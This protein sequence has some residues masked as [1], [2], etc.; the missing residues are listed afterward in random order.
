MKWNHRKDLKTKNFLEPSRLQCK[1]CTI[2]NEDIRKIPHRLEEYR[3][4]IRLILLGLPSEEAG[5]RES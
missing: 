2:G 5:Y 4:I 1:F 3:H